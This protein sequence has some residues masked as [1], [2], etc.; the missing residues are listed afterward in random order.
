MPIYAY[1]CRKCGRR[2]EEWKRIEERLEVRCECGEKGEIDFSQFGKHTIM[3]FTPYIYTDI[4]VYP[5]EITSKRQLKRECEKRGLV[6]A[7][8][9]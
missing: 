8:L 6:A 9:L 7:R 5:I 1:K 3:F 2:W 4:D